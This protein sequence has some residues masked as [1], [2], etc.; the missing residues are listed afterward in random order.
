MTH[1]Q[2]V[3]YFLSIVAIILLST[4]A[5]N[6]IID[7]MEIWKVCSI[8]G[9]NVLKPS[10]GDYDRF[11][12][13]VDIIEKKPDAVLF[14]TS[15]VQV[16]IDPDE[17]KNYGYS[18][19]YNSALS[20][21]TLEEQ[22]EYLKHAVYNNKEIKLVIIGLD[23]ESFIANDISYRSGF[24]EERMQMSRLYYRDVLETTL[25]MDMAIK[26]FETIK[27]NIKK[28]GFSYF[29]ENG[30]RTDAY[31]Y[32]LTQRTIRGKGVQQA[33]MAPLGTGSNTNIN[34][35]KLEVFK[36]FVQLCKNNNIKLI[37]FVTPYHAAALERYNNS[38]FKSFEN[39]KRE[40]TKITTVWDF[41][42]YNE[43][44]TESVSEN[45]T[46]YWEASHYKKTVG[47]RMLERMLGG[48]LSPPI[49]FGKLLN[50]DN[51][52]EHLKDIQATR[53]HGKQGLD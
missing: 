5:F 12:K 39:W 31:Q 19:A 6:I 3:R 37:V 4:A 48:D 29:E 47:K 41:S 15:R 32:N 11:K 50:S 14:G 7:P 43:I 13:A 42:G 24:R 26:S 17:L 33:F 18:K 44:T 53:I 36:E 23:F 52:D 2:F 20:A 34:N 22:L 30:A 46:Y 21:G 49:R 28:D 40:I 8:K 45:M 10:P 35:N 38:G 27:T 25:S 9:L 51:F 1:K 16:G